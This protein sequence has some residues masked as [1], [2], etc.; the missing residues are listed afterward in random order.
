M[1]TGMEDAANNYVQGQYNIT[2]LHFSVRVMVGVERLN[3]VRENLEIN[4]GWQRWTWVH[5]FRLTLGSAAQNDLKLSQVIEN[6]SI[7]TGT[8]S[9]RFATTQRLFSS[10]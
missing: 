10:H 5:I 3:T 4:L 8:G 6:T 1:I 9:L 2:A 7:V